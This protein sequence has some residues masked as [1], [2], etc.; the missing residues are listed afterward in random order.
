MKR[1]FSVEFCAGIISNVRALKNMPADA[2]PS[3]GCRLFVCH[4]PLHAG[5]LFQ[6]SRWESLPLFRQAARGSARVSVAVSTSFAVGAPLC[7]FAPSQVRPC[8]RMS[9]EIHGMVQGQCQKLRQPY[10]HLSLSLSLLDNTIICSYF[11]KTRRK[12]Y[13][14]KNLQIFHILKFD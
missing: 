8:T 11:E 9:V 1:Y 6:A 3:A 13:N 10:H 14:F 5:H 4:R 2:L 12:N 7:K